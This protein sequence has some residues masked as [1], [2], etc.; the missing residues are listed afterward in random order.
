MREYVAAIDQGTTGTRCI[1]FDR[2]GQAVASAYREHDADLSAAGLGRARS[3]R[4]PRA[5]RRGRVRGA[6]R[7]AGRARARG[8]DHEPARDGRG[9]GR[10]RRPP[11]RERDRLAG[12]AHR[13]GVPRRDREGMGRGRAPPHGPS[14]LDLLLGDE[15]PLAPRSRPAL[16]AARPRAGSSGSGRSTPG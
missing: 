12:H 16:P 4:D 15:D 13:A 10:A 1:L 3:R 6:A 8:R 5:R 11:R 2:A 9:L 7:G 14:H